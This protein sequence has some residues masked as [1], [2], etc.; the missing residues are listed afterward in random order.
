MHEARTGRGGRREEEERWGIRNFNDCK[1]FL[2]FNSSSLLELPVAGDPS[3]GF[4]PLP[5]SLHRWA[6]LR[7]QVG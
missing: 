4:C 1:R 6:R 7:R 3:L 2:T 5:P